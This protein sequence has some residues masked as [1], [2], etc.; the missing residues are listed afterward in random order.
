MVLRVEDTATLTVAREPLRFETF[1]LS[2]SITNGFK[3]RLL[4]L[5]GAGPVVLWAS[6]NLLS[7]DPLL[8]NGPVIGYLDLTDPHATNQMFRFYRATEGP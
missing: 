1:A 8:S 6:S 4:G 2:L 5:A 3:L 7:W